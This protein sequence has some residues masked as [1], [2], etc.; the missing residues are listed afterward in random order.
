MCVILCGTSLPSEQSSGAPDLQLVLPATFVQARLPISLDEPNSRSSSLSL[1][2][3]AQ[4]QYLHVARIVDGLARRELAKGCHRKW[5][6][7]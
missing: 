7:F 6:S 2:Q 5:W 4:V 1:A 3:N